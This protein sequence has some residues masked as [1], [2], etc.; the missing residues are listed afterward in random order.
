MKKNMKLWR[1]LPVCQLLLACV[2]F[3][4]S[5]DEKTNFVVNPATL[6]S[7]EAS[8]EGSCFEIAESWKH[9]AHNLLEVSARDFIN[10]E[11]VGTKCQ[12]EVGV[13]KEWNPFFFNSWRPVDGFKYNM[14][15]TLDYFNWNYGDDD[16]WNLHVIPTPPF[17]FLISDVEVLHPDSVDD[18]LKCGPPFSCM[19]AEVS[20][21]K[22][23]WNNPWFSLPST[24][25]PDTQGNGHSFLEGRQMGFYGPW[26][27]DANHD[28]RSEIHPID[29]MW[30]KDRFERGVGGSGP[31]L[32]IFWLMLLQD[33]TGRFDDRD[34]FDCDGSAPAGW[35]PWADSPRSGQFNV[36]FEVDPQREAANFFIFELFNRF[37]VT[38]QDGNAR[39]D[40]DD[41]KSHAL[42]I[43][44]RVV[45]RVEEEQPN[46]DDLG[47]TFTNLCLGADGKLRG[48]VSIRSKIGG[49][50]DRDEEGFHIFYVTRSLTPTRPGAVALD[51]ADL[52]T[53]LLTSKE[54]GG[55]LKGDGN[56][57]TGDLQLTL[58]GNDRTTDRD[59]AISKIEFAGQDIRRELRFEQN[60]RAKEVLIRDL[61]L[62]SDGTLTITSSSGLILKLRT[63]TLSPSPGIEETITRSAIDANA[64]RFL[65]A[66]VGGIPGASLPKD[67]K[68][69]ALQE[70][71][72]KFHPLY[73]PYEGNE[74][75]TDTPSA[76]ASEINQAIAKNEQKKLEEL[77]NSAQPF[78]LAWTFEATNLATG[79]PVAVYTDKPGAEGVQIELMSGNR[80]N[81]TLKIK[82]ASPGSSGIIELRAKAS[83]TDT[84]GKTTIVEHRVWSHGFQ[85]TS[86]EVDEWVPLIQALAGVKDRSALLAPWPPRKPQQFSLVPDGKARHAHIMNAYLRETVRD[87]QITIEEL[88]SIIRALKKFSVV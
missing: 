80:A 37:V 40:A 20:P 6:C 48:F 84:K 64:G 49:N 18:H 76:F 24:N 85:S 15:A 61:P 5:C 12:G 69:S 4:S 38:S 3:S 73:A 34:N 88:R 51:V 50:D 74:V 87:R 70:L 63:P 55:S 45:V 8:I 57:F 56:H 33:N 59:Y 32:D 62:V 77:F 68:L 78:T 72:L 16:D 25:P 1:L 9:T 2:L 11:F 60:K 27:M 81:D 79:R 83:V 46:D 44:G 67:K 66:S 52:P 36:A 14:S 21:D 29:M 43:N 47:V 54:M 17:S 23:F 7:C 41:G 42:E 13:A 39:Q 75:I 19:E 26:I 82:F 58:H 86:K 10:G 65:S 28:F 31:P 53:L 22:Q 30:F 35:R 71:Q